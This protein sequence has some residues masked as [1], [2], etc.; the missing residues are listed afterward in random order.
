MQGLRNFGV[1]NWYCTTSGVLQEALKCI[2]SYGLQCLSSL[3]AQTE[4]LIL[5]V[6]TSINKAIHRRITRLRMAVLGLSTSQ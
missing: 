3:G 5:I 2:V 6:R 4:P 1:V